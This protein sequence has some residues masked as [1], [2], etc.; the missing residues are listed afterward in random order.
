[1]KNIFFEFA[2]M[3]F[4]AQEGCTGNGVTSVLSVNLSTNEVE[5]VV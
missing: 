2:I 4:P 1:M 5:K 3:G